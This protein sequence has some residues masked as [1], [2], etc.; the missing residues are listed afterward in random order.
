MIL[1]QYHFRKLIYVSAGIV[2]VKDEDKSTKFTV[3]PNRI[4]IHPKRD[5]TTRS[6]DLAVLTVTRPFQF[7]RNVNYICLASPEDHLHENTTVGLN[8]FLSFHEYEATG[9]GL[10]IWENISREK[11]TKFSKSDVCLPQPH[12]TQAM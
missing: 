7:S 2:Y 8:L 6:Y 5:A 11:W 10:W 12:D 9:P 1:V 3:D 4:F